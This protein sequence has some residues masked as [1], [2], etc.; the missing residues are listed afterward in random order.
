MHNE[1]EATIDAPADQ[2][3]AIVSDLSRYPEFLAIVTKV[4]PADGD[5]GSWWVTLRAKIGPF[6]RSKRLR[7]VRTVAETGAR[8]RFERVEVD[9]RQHSPWTLE[10]RVRPD[11]DTTSVVTMGLDYGGGLWSGA[12]D[13]VLRAEVDDAGQRLQDLATAAV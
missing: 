1:F 6:A 3:Y 9:G 10:A 4:E 7:M 2:V 12:I 11:G 13:A 5:D 8:A